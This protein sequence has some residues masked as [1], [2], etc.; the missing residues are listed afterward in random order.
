MVQIQGVFAELDKSLLVRKLCKAREQK[1]VE[2]GKCEG[3]KGY[4]D[5]PEGIAL[6]KGYKSTMDLNL[7]QKPWTSGLMNMTLSWIFPGL[8]NQRITRL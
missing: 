8:E 5:T 3:R 4:K 7:F 6:P 2:S 1:R